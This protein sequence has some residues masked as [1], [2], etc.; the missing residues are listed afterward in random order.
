MF[1]A[2]TIAP[3]YL[4]HRIYPI[5]S[6]ISSYIIYSMSNISNHIKY[7]STIQQLFANQLNQCKSPVPVEVTQPTN[8]REPVPQR[9]FRCGVG[10]GSI[11]AMVG[12]GDTVATN[13]RNK[14]QIF[15]LMT[16]C[17][18]CF[19]YITYIGYI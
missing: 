1:L 11:V 5:I 8:Y 3:I 13:D 4:K 2:C 10:S 15:E 7:I 17:I 18:E 12:G 6:G 16:K 19:E 14:P 9:G